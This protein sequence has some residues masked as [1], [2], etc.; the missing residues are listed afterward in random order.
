MEDG[1]EYPRI[2]TPQIGVLP[3][4]IMYRSEDDY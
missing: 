3:M 2:L 4:R 1:W